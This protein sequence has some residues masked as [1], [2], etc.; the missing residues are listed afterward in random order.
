[1]IEFIQGK[2]VE[3]TPA[4]AVLENQG[5][6][7]FLNISVNTY[8][9]IQ[10]KTECRLFVHEAIRE[11]AYV[12]Y[13]FA[14]T[15]EREAFRK[16]ISVSGI[17]ANTARII[18][19]SLNVSELETAILAE[20][21]AIFKNIKGIGTKTAQRIIVEL[22]DKVGKSG[23][24][25]ENALQAAV[26]GGE[27]RNEALLALQ[28]LGFSTSASAKAIDSILSKQPALTVEQLIKAALKLL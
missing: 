15:D 10:E 23:L 5:M 25:A 20:N 13:G 26:K 18:L 27:V 14:D 19:S 3:L 24:G 28:M 11:D 6:G 9:A 21:V 22:K 17:G 12:L 1:M 7:F 2:I 4:S 8:S 16:L